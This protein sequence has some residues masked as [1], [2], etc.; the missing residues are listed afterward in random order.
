MDCSVA[1]VRLL[2]PVSRKPLPRVRH[3]QARIEVG[4]HSIVDARVASRIHPLSWRGRNGTGPNQGGWDIT[5]LKGPAKW[6]YYYCERWLKPARNW[7]R[8]QA[9]PE[10]FTGVEGLRKGVSRIGVTG[11]AKLQTEVESL[12]GVVE[13]AVAGVCQGRHL[14]VDAAFTLSLKKRL[15]LST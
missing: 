14:E 13:V 15:A 9:A 8:A 1:G 11:P 6:T 10:S 2:G 12:E 4:D 3:L 7:R 5:M